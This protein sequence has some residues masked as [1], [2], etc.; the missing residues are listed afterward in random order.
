MTKGAN[1]VSK[2]LFACSKMGAIIILLN[3]AYS[4]IEIITALS[5]TRK[6]EILGG[7]V[8]ILKARFCSVIQDQSMLSKP[9]IISI[10]SIISII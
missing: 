6:L 9:T 5:I 1:T 8:S 4:H 3:Y 7:S 10:I 2:L